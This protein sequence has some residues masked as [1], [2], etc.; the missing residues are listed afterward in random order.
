MF[1]LRADGMTR[2]TDECQP[3]G[4]TPIAVKTTENGLEF[5][6]E[7]NSRSPVPE[8]WWSGELENAKRF[9]LALSRWGLLQPNDTIED[10]AEAITT[11]D[12]QAAGYQLF[13]CELPACTHANSLPR[14]W[15]QTF[16]PQPPH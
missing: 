11:L 13:P 3:A 14:F 7:D 6:Y 10:V 5:V 15:A 8:E 12:I 1:T 2:I 4:Q 9:A 16:K